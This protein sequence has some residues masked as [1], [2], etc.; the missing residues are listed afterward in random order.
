MWSVADDS[1]ALLME[2]FY[3][4]LRSGR[5]KDSALR[6]AQIDVI[7]TLPEFSDPYHWAAFALMGD[8]K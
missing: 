8:W 1:T 4:H 7:R 2:R 5:S 3:H 6:Q